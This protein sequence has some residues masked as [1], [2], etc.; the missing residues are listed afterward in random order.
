MKTERRE[1]HISSAW[2]CWLTVSHNQYQVLM[3]H[4]FCCLLKGAWTLYWSI[5]GET[6]VCST[7]Q[8]ASLSS[9]TSSIP[10][11]F[12]TYWCCSSFKVWNM[13]DYFIKYQS[14]CHSC[15]HESLYASR[16][17]AHPVRPG[18]C[19]TWCRLFLLLLPYTILVTLRGHTCLSNET[20]PAQT[21]EM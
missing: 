11:R 19:G 16:L 10:H 1:A 18:P 3:M 5:H 6:L 14:S 8:T 15:W 21:G 2:L 12:K 7:S 17:Q 4:L 20:D 13:P 9:W